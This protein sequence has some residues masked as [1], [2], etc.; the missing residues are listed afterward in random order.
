MRNRSSWWWAT[1][2]V[3]S[4]LG[5]AGSVQGQGPASQAANVADMKFVTLPGLPTCATGSVQDGD[6]TRGPSIILAK[7]ASGCAVPWH[8]HTPSERVMIVAGVGRAEMKD[9]KPVALRPGGFALMPSHHVHRY[10]CEGSCEFSIY[11]DAAFDIH[12]VDGQGQEIAA[13]QALKAVGETVA[14]E[15]R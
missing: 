10:S 9:G 2:A 12:Y 4:I 3:S 15:M 5:L 8:W 1:I 7:A 13:N 11:S 14:T 6:P